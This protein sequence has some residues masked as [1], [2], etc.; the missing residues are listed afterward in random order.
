[1][2]LCGVFYA[3]NAW[4]LNVALSREPLP[5]E[6]ETWGWRE[7]KAWKQK[8]WWDKDKHRR[9]RDHALRYKISYQLKSLRN[10]KRRRWDASSMHDWLR[11][12]TD[13]QLMGFTFAAVN[14]L[15]HI[16]QDLEDIKAVKI[17][18]IQTDLRRIVQKEMDDL[19][20]RLS[21]RNITKW[22]FSND[23]KA[24]HQEYHRA[25]Y[26]ILDSS[27]HIY[28]NKKTGIK[29][30]RI[31]VMV[32]L[33]DYIK[34]KSILNLES[35]SFLEWLR[36]RIRKYVS[37]RFRM[38]AEVK[39]LVDNKIDAMIPDEEMGGDLDAEQKT[40]SQ[41]KKKIDLESKITQEDKAGD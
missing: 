6:W 29:Y 38:L 10:F 9:R 2:G 8:Y 17:V 24:T 5:P 39:G 19:K 13:K 15:N 25:A 26:K 28:E 41:R 1:M 22:I 4:R 34:F 20:S 30:K 35:T 40:K 3:I 27:K 21:K 16:I 12:V 36:L 23:G 37:L 14:K 7:R 18:P 11:I 33:D 32:E 31:T